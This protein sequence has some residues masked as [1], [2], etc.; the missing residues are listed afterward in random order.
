MCHCDNEYVERSFQRL[1]KR[2]KHQSYNAK[3]SKIFSRRARFDNVKVNEGQQPL[4]IL[5]CTIKTY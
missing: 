2:I 4:M 1:K 5:F 3:V